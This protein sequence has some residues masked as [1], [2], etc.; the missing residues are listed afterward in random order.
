MHM[1]C[2]WLDGSEWQYSLDQQILSPTFSPICAILRCIRLY[3]ISPIYFLAL[4]QHL[5]L[6]FVNKLDMAASHIAWR[7]DMI[8]R[9]R[10]ICMNIECLHANACLRAL[11]KASS[12]CSMQSS[13]P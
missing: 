5:C 12:P 2:K 11:T 8:V 4:P 10:Q 9:L 3:Y 6:Q 13:I 7:L 1:C